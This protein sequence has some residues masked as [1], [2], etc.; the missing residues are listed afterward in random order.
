MDQNFLT[1]EEAKKTSDDELSNKLS[2]N[3]LGLTSSEAEKRAPARVNSMQELMRAKRKFG[4]EH[5]DIK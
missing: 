1:A 5:N 2:A 3:P 4:A